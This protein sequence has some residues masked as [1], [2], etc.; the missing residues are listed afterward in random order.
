MITRSVP[1]CVAHG[2]NDF[3]IIAWRNNS[4]AA[5]MLESESERR[6]ISDWEVGCS[7]RENEG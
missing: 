7:E 6:V 1:S 5:L 2:V 4:S 3:R